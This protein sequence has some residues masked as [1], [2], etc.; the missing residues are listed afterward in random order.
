[1]RMRRWAI[2][3]TTV[4][5]GAA[6]TA[7][8]TLMVDVE[9]PEV[10]VVADRRVSTTP[11]LELRFS[12]PMD[13]LTL[14]TAS[15]VLVAHRRGG[16]CE[17][18]L[19]CDPAAQ[20]V[21]GICQQEVVDAGWLKDLSHPPLS[22]SRLALTVPLSLEL[23]ERGDRALV[24]PGV[25]LEPDRLH[26]LLIAPTLRDLRG[27]R[28]AANAVVRH[29]FLTDDGS[30]AK[31]RP[32]LVWPTD[33]DVAVP[34]NLYSV[35]FRFDKKVEGVSRET[36]FLVGSDGQRVGADI[37]EEVPLCDSWPPGECYAL[38]PWKWLEPR[39]TYTLT[40]A[41]GIWDSIGQVPLISGPLRFATGANPDHVAPQLSHL[42][43]L[44]ADQCLA[45][46]FQPDERVEVAISLA[47]T[48]ELSVVASE[49][50][51]EV[52]LRTRGIWGWQTVDIRL[53]DL[54]GN[55]TLYRYGLH[56]PMLPRISISEV[57][58]NPSG[59]EPA[60]E[61]VEVYNDENSP[62]DVGGWTLDDNDDGQGVNTLPSAVI[63]PRNFALVVG[64][65][66]RLQDMKGPLPPPETLIIR[67]G[68]TLGSQGLANG[69]ETLALRDRLGRLVSLAAARAA[70]G[71]GRST[72]RVPL[73]S[74]NLAD[75][76]RTSPDD[77]PSPGAAPKP[78]IPLQADSKN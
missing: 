13:P 15:V 25:R 67:L 77:G 12:R 71:D 18:D 27:N 74:C 52:A 40:F 32:Q 8:S 57:M 7:G 19:A 34:T 47:S 3:L 38:R 54:S 58:A 46:N 39:T 31:P 56:L 14:T 20:C 75:N 1:M 45:L 17:V 73:G 5:S 44:H 43:Q 78:E 59:A 72:E 51:H 49:G 23:N 4:I 36:V 53:A 76:W 55:A 29:E 16:V 63:Q 11:T 21:E 37:A 64:P 69:G 22:D 66:F 6:C 48:S 10:E 65:K 41:G 33:G 26:T 62:I 24:T 60:Q 9:A 28:L 35:V 61:W 42:Q 2:I 30:R 70:S 68:E 50:R